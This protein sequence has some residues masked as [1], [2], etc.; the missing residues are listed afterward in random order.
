MEG[1]YRQ[2]LGA[3][4][5]EGW[6]RKVLAKHK[7]CFRG[8]HLSLGEGRRGVTSLRVY[9]EIPDG[10]KVRFLGG[11]ETAIKSWCVILA[12]CDFFFLVFFST[13]GHQITR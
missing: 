7:A 3:G 4:E 13:V 10:F 11:A 5:E 9:Q 8:G 6:T 2:K 12:A 1:S